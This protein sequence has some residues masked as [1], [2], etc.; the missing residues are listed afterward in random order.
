MIERPFAVA[1]GNK[2]TS[3]AAEIIL[4]QGGNAYDAVLA[5]LFMSFVSE[6]LLSSPG[7]GGY[8]LAHPLGEKPEILDF[9]AQ[10]PF[11]K[12]TPLKDFFPIHGDFGETS[13]EFHIG[14]AAA[15][16]P[17]I[18]A[19]IFKIHKNFA[20]MPLGVLAKPA[21]DK[22]RSGLLVDTHYENIIQI[23]APILSSTT[24]ANEIFSNS[25]NNFL[26]KG[27]LQ[28]NHQLADFMVELT[29]NDKDWFYLDRPMKDIVRDMR[30][31]HGL[32][33]DTDFKNYQ[34]ISRSPRQENIDGWNLITNQA[35]TTGGYLIIEQLKHALMNSSK[36]PQIRIVEAMMHADY[37]KISGEIHQNSKGTTH[38]SVI[39]A[40][41]NIASLTV[42]N[43]EGCGYVVPGCGFM[44]NNFLGEEDINSRG[45]F[46]FES[47]SRMASM[48]SPSIL[49]KD[50]MKIALGSGGS[51][52]IKTAIFQVIYQIIVQ[53]KNL[54]QAVNEPRLHYE[55]NILDIEPGL[56][57]SLSE[58][59]KYN[60][61]KI[62]QWNH[63]SLYFGGVNAAQTG[64]C[65]AATGD[66]RRKGSGII[67]L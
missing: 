1:T 34:V 15:A 6:P 40:K 45:F 41:G 59:Q 3:Q 51:N 24:Q 48:M 21:I 12:E 30:E 37:L 60:F 52:R 2:H 31:G 28:K 42:S 23:L 50:D 57:K 44:L 4:R 16:T 47:N 46:N 53:G 27:D 32:L 66:S 20:T 49:E 17:G 36:T 63:R 7:G 43:G 64:H 55:N 61:S 62:N 29:S 56:E 13:Q 39:D 33:N 11:S 19:G 9:F 65:C 5:A 35:P 58:L 10:T 54:N 67:G 25:K 8:L 14:K 26:E 38:M 18:P 22:A